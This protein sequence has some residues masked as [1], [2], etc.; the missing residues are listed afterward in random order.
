MLKLEVRPEPSRAMSI[1]SPLIALA[2]TVVIG[3]CL[4]L[5]SARTRCAASPSSSSSR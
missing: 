5:L 3:T 1:A 2:I 4:F